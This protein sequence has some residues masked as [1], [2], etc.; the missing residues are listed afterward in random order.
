MNKVDMIV[1]LQFGSTGKGLLS[2]FLAATQTNRPYDVVV[3][4]NMPNA[5]HTFIDASG[6][7]MIFKVLPN[8]IVGPEVEVALLGPGSVFSPKR[9][10]EEMSHAAL[11]GYNHFEVAIHPNATVVF[12]SDV[13]QEQGLIT[14]IGS[15]AQGSMAAQIKKMQRDPT[16]HCL[17]KHCMGEI[18]RHCKEQPVAVVHND[19][20]DAIVKGAEMILAEGSQGHSLGINTVFYPY[21]TSRDCSPARFLSDMGIPWNMLRYVVGVA[22]LHPIRVGGNSG[23]CWP[24]QREISW[25]ELQQE[26]EK[27]TVTNRTRRVFSFSAMQIEHAVYHCQPTSVFLN[28]CNYARDPEELEVVLGYFED[29]GIKVGWSGWGPTI[30]DIALVDSKLHRDKIEEMFL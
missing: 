6:N 13:E 10:A 5:G 8:G 20:Y 29:S 23:P 16:V 18:F 15:T 2:G 21:V 12:D 7:K 27:T 9:L 11:C 22:R 25:R 26:P 14:T 17:A 30:H 19:D 3:N 4:C 24:D 28:F 1:D